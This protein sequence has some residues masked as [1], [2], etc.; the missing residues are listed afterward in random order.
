MFFAEYY[1]IHGWK[2]AMHCSIPYDRLSECSFRKSRKQPPTPPILIPTAGTSDVGV[3]AQWR[4]NA[5]LE[6]IFD[7]GQLY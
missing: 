1:Y 4:R 2:L 5:S 7:I 3:D 6:S